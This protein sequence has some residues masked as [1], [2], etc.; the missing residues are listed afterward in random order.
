VTV[1]QDEKLQ[2]H[3]WGISVAA[4]C[5]M[6][7]AAVVFMAQIRPL[8]AK[9]VFQ[10]EVSLV[11]PV[12]QETTVEPAKPAPPSPKPRVK[13]AQPVEPISQVE[14]TPQVVTRRVQTA[15]APAIVQR[16]SPRIVE[17]MK[18]IER[19]AAVQQRQEA[20]TETPQAHQ[21][22]VEERPVEQ[23]IQ[24]TA[25]H[26]PVVAAAAQPIVSQAPVVSSAQPAETAGVATPVHEEPVVRTEA[27]VTPSQEIVASPP[28]VAAEEAPPVQERRIMPVIAPSPSPA[29][30][31]PPV[32]VAKAAPQTS[33]V[34]ADHRWVGE[35]LWR[36]VA[37]L[38]RYP[39][40]AR[41]NGLEGRVVLKAVIRAD[42]HLAEV[43][44][45]KSSGHAVLDAAALEAVKLACPLHM[46]HELGKP[47]IVVS[48]P[49]VYS[50]AQ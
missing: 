32:Q 31:E 7:G 50:L 45:I 35:S 39:S 37:E 49:I 21:L 13:P 5:L 8:P 24:A 17:T 48:L 36:R 26:E 18:P 30:G 4:H 42:G 16:D 34:R 2:L 41:L 40:S 14:P 33:E 27:V 23:A 44:V 19:T 38:K 29:V 22:H 3:A 15:E 20:A 43:S 9:D 28:T 11:Q 47:Q 12:V 10:W 25:T 1:T 46:K 6:V